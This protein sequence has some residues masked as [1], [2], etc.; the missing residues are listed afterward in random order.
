MTKV[1]C[2]W[3]ACI[4]CD[5]NGCCTKDFIRLSADTADDNEFEYLVCEDY[6]E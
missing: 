5:E 2:E 6:A 1:Y 3:D 4:H